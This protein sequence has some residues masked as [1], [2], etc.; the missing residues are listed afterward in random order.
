MT[1]EYSTSNEHRTINASRRIQEAQSALSMR[2]PSRSPHE[3]RIRR[4]FAPTVIS[5][6]KILLLGLGE[7][8]T[9][10]ATTLRRIAGH[11]QRAGH[12][13]VF[14]A[15]EGLEEKTVPMI[16]HE[17]QCN[18]ALGVHAYGAGKL[19]RHLP[20]PT[21]IVFGGTDLNECIHDDT[22]KVVM[23]QA[24]E[25]ASALVC[26]NQ[27]F[28][29]RASHVWPQ[30]RHKLHLIHKSVEV[31]PSWF[32]RISMEALPTDAMFYLLPA[33]L[34]EVK[35]PLFLGSAIAAWHE[36]DQ[37]IHLL[38][39]GSKRDPAYAQTVRAKVRA[40]PGILV[41]DPIPQPD[42]WALMHE[43]E[44]VLNTS[45]SESSPNSLLEAMALG[46]P[47]LARDIPG[48]RALVS[49]GKTGMLFATPETFVAC[50]KRLHSDHALR[51]RIIAGAQKR[52][53]TDFAPEHEARAYATLFATIG[54]RDSR[55]K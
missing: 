51:E 14:Q 54:T 42:L 46:V 34:R 25:H 50:A 20:I 9:G 43:A 38:I 30:I 19:L 16:A 36:R 24:V 22:K 49:D 31:S 28:L 6:M 21:V 41:M 37:R 35:D 33:G 15:I 12:E 7:K 48:N 18:A 1:R 3:L 26:F 5:H 45:R 10:N 44:A 29:N 13:I 52:L 55:T 53:E 4:K 2:S 23:T 40:L 47:V 39:V 32:S 17:K 11:L 8:A 27:D